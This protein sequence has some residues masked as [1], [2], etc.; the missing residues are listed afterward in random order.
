MKTIVPKNMASQDRK[1]YVVDAK[2]QNLG[3]L[4]TKIATVLRGKNKVDF[5]SHYDNGD[6]VVVINCNQF[7]VSGTK[8]EEKMYY[9]H[10]GYLGGVK[11]SNLAKLLTKKPEKPL[12]LAVFGMLPKN[13]LRK[14][15]MARLKMFTGAEHT[16][17]AQK[18]EIIN[19]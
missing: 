13:K 1:W 10:S 16:F 3:K 12:E 11:S 9:T 5:I 19:L 17:T 6:Y 18:P 14:D 15:M 7:S 8:M 4:A 2:G